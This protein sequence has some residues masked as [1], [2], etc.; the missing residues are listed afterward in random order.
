MD[1]GCYAKVVSPGGKEMI[2]KEEEQ[3]PFLQMVGKMDLEDFLSL[4]KSGALSCCNMGIN[5]NT[6]SYAGILRY[7]SF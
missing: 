2:K 4:W 7:A 3:Q 5:I 1:H 6:P